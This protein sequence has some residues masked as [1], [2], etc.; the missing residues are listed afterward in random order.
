MWLIHANGAV[1]VQM[2]KIIL[3]AKI[4]CVLGVEFDV[5]TF[6]S[7]PS[8]GDF[9]HSRMHSTYVSDAEDVLPNDIFGPNRVSNNTKVSYSDFISIHIVICMNVEL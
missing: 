1:Q 7:C 8:D 2:A 6:L 4:S 9:G 5:S 3:Q